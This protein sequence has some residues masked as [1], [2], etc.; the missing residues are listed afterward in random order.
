MHFKPSWLLTFSST[1]RSRYVLS[2]MPMVAGVVCFVPPRRPTLVY[3]W[4][5]CLIAN[6]EARIPT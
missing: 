5:G 1:L 4:R 2:I 3:R 6:L